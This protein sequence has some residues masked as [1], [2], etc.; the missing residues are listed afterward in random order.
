MKVEALAYPTRVPIIEVF[1]TKP[2]NIH[3]N[4]FISRLS[5]H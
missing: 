1:S 3:L 5:Q 4:D 2:N